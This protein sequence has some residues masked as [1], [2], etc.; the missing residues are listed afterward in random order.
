MKPE[1]KKLWLE[2]LRSGKYQ[3]CQERLCKMDTQDDA[4]NQSG[5]VVG[6]CCL[7]VLTKVCIPLMPPELQSKMENRLNEAQLLPIEVADFANL[8]IIKR[9][10]EVDITVNGDNLSTLNDGRSTLGIKEHNFL[11]IADLIEK[12]L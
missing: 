2:A 5:N 12:Y 9:D 11:E 3:Q 8:T 1:I 10:T 7:G 6:Y 4:G